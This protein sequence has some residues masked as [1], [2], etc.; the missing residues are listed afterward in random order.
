MAKVLQIIDI[1]N[2][3][4]WWIYVQVV[5]ICRNSQSAAWTTKAASDKQ[6]LAFAVIFWLVLSLHLSSQGWN[7]I[8]SLYVWCQCKQEASIES[9]HA[10]AISV[11][12]GHCDQCQQCT[13]TLQVSPNATFVNHMQSD[14]IRFKGRWLL[15]SKESIARIKRAGLAGPTLF[16]N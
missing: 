8:S 2:I 4:Y 7:S 16:D 1:L 3:Y 6:W 5:G 15:R 14:L 13:L 11:F 10:S 12:A 9:G